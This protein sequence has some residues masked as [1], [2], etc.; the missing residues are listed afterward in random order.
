MIVAVGNQ[1]GGVGKSTLTMNFAVSYQNA[2]LDVIV[3]E[4]D[5]SVRTVSQWGQDRAEQEM[6]PIAVIRQQGKIS[7]VLRDLGKRYDVVLVDLPGKD[8]KELRSAFLAADIAVIPAQASQADVD[9]TME[10]AE[11]ID[12][13][14]DFNESLRVAVALNRVPTHCWNEEALEARSI[15]EESF[16]K[17]FNTVIHE[18]KVFRMAL[19]SGSSAVESSDRKARQEIDELA[20][21]IKEYV[22]E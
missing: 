2:G 19:R 4:A 7:D 20:T 18:R 10:M 8:S 1:K 5:P 15:L 6:P 3:V 11:I 21:E 22:H 17:V 13:A 9:T 16:G 14:R 12:T